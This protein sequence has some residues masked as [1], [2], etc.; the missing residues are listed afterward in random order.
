MKVIIYISLDIDKELPFHLF[1]KAACNNSHIS[2]VRC[3]GPVRMFITD[4]DNQDIVKGY[5]E[6]ECCQRWPKPVIIK[7]LQDTFSI[8][9]IATDTV[10]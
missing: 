7:D 8:L 2:E 1:F 4:K 5:T 9:Q 6:T 3:P 10:I